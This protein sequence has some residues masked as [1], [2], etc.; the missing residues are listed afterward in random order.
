MRM[1]TYQRL[2]NLN[3]IFVD[4][5]V[6]TGTKTKSNVISFA[7]RLIVFQNFKPNEKVI[8]KFSVKNASTVI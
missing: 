3:N 4:N 2:Q 5:I 1:D 6:N 7:P 8:A